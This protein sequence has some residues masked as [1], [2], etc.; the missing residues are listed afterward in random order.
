MQ[1]GHFAVGIFAGLLFALAI[2]ASAN[3]FVPNQT[4]S[5]SGL[6]P[7]S[8]I[9]LGTTETSTSGSTSTR[10]VQSSSASTSSVGAQAVPPAGAYSAGNQSKTATTTS[11]STSSSSLQSTKNGTG[12]QAAIS[13]SSQ[14]QNG[15]AQGSPS[16][17]RDFLSQPAQSL[18]FLIPVFAAL[19]FGLVFYKATAVK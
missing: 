15:G 6:T 1:Q 19:F 13:G 11:V 8:N 2:V 14:T 17:V 3:L 18:V 9:A 7:A 5:N 16:S 10:A 12:V 4:S